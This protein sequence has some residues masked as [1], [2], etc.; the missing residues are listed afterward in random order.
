MLVSSGGDVYLSNWAR[1][2]D[3]CK[4]AACTLYCHTDSAYFCN[5]CDQRIH[6]ANSSALTHQRVWVCTA[7]ENAPVAVTCKADAASLCFTCDAEIHSVNALARRHSRI[8]MP[9]FSG[10]A[11]A[12]SCS[13]TDDDLPGT[14]LDPHNEIMANTT[15]SEEIDEDEACSWLLLEPDNDENQA[16]SGFSFSEPVDEYIDLRDSCTGYQHQETYSQLQSSSTCLDENGSDGVVPEKSFDMKKQVQPQQQHQ[17]QPLLQQQ[18]NIN[19]NKEQEASR[20]AFINT[21]TSSQDVRS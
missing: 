18:Q 16:H 7:C 4:A 8:P 11:Y 6:A 14:V 20:T 9:P 2:C 15:T 13:Y 19:F 17:Q 3:T 5:D 1:A 10:L 21:P 12:S